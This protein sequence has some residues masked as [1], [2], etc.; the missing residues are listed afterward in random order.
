MHTSSKKHKTSYRLLFLLVCL[1]VITMIQPQIGYGQEPD[2]NQLYLP[3]ILSSGG[4]EA[5]PPV[6]SDDHDD[7]Y[8]AE[9]AQ[10]Y[11]PF[12]VSAVRRVVAPQDRDLYGEWGPLL[13]WP[14]IPVSAANLPDGRIITWAS[15]RVD[16]FPGGQPEFTYSSVWDPATGNF[17]T[18]NETGH[19][20]FCAHTVML[21]DGQVMAAGGRNTVVLTSLFNA[22]TNDW[23]RDD[24]MVDPRWYPT[25]VA[26]PDDEVFVVS[27][28]GGSNTAEVWDRNAGWRRLNNINWS[29]VANAAGFESHWW[30]YL[31]IAPD[32]RLAHTG[33]TDEMH[34]VT[35]SGNGS[36]TN[37]GSLV[38]N[39]WY[40]K[41]GAV[42]MYDVGKILIAGGAANTSGGS[43]DNVIT[44]D[45]NTNN[46]QVT[47]VADMTFAR[48]FPN[49][50]MLPNGKVL[51]LGGNTSGTKFSDN[52]TILAA[53]SWDPQT[54]QWTEL[55][56]AGAPR[57]YHSVGLLLPDGR[58]LSGGGGL[59]GGCS[60]NHQNS[61]IFSP[62]YLFQADGSLASRPSITNAPDTVGLGAT[63][64]V[65]ATP[66]MQQFSL[67]KMT[68]T[69]HGWSSDVRYLDVPFTETSSGTYQLTFNNNVNVLLAGYW[70][71]FALDN[72]GVPSEAKIVRITTDNTPWITPPGDQ[73]NFEED[74]VNLAITAGDPNGDTLTFSATGLPAG[75]SINSNTGIIAGTLPINS[76]TVN[77]V[78]VTVSDGTS[79]AS[80]SFTWSVF[81]SG[82]GNGQILREWWTGIGGNA[83]SSLT[84]NANYPDN[85]TGSETISI[86]ETPSNFA[87]SYG[88]RVRGYVHA[89]ITGQYRFWIAT[90][91]NGELWLSSDGNP[92]NVSLI[93]NVPGWTSPRQ[94]NKFTQQQS[95]LITLQAGQKYYIEALQKEGGGLDN[96]AVAWQIPG[97]S[98]EVIDGLYL[99]PPNTAPSV[100]NPGAQVSQINDIVSLTINAT[101]V[102]GDALTF[103]A[104]GLPSGLSI[105]ASTGEIA[106]TATTTGSFNATV[107]VND[108]TV[109]ND[110]SFVW[111]VNPEGTIISEFFESGAGDFTYQDDTFRGTNAASYASGAYLAT[112][113]DNGSGGLQVLLGGIDDNNILGMSGGWQTTFNL[114]QPATI[115]LSLRYILNLSSE[116]ESD[117]FGQT[118]FSLNGVLYGQGSNDYIAQINGNGGG[119][120]ID[121]TGWQTFSLNNVA[122]PAGTHTLVMGGYNNKKTFNNETTEVIIDDVLI[123][124]VTP[125][126]QTPVVTNP[127]NQTDIAGNTVS[128]NITASDGDND[129][130]TYSATGLP[131]GLAINNSTGEIAGTLT[132]GGVFNVTVTV[133]DGTDS[134]SA[135]F[136]WTVNISSINLAPMTS[137]PKEVGTS[138]NYTANASGGLNLQYKWDFGDGTGETSY[139]TSASINHTFNQP[140]RYLVTVYVKSDG[141]EEVFT[142]FWQAAYGTPTANRPA[143]SMSV[144][145]EMR[146]GADY[147][148]N[149]NPDNN[150]VSAFNTNNGN[151]VA[152]IPVQNAPRALAFAP[153]GRLWVTNKHSGSISIINTNTLAVVQTINLP[154]ASQPFGLAFDPA[155]SA[156]YVALEAAGQ[157]L[158]LNPNTGTQIDSVSLGLNIRHISVSA[159][160]SQ[161]LVSRFITPPM[162][163]EDT[164]NPQTEV[165]GNKL[166]GEVILVNASSMTIDNTVILQHSEEADSEASA[167][168]IPNYLGVAT[169]SPDGLSAWVPSKQDNIKRGLLR[170]GNDLDH[171]NTVRSISSRINLGSETEDYPARVDHDDGGIASTAIYG[172]YGSY[173]F[174]ALEGSREVAVLDPYGEAELFRFDVGFAPQGLA[175]SEDGLTLYVHNFLDRSVGVHDLTTLINA[176]E[177]TVSLIDTY[178]TVANE[179]LTA[180][181]LN[182]KKLF[183]DARDPR[184]GLQ[185]YISC[186][187]CHNDGGHDGRT[188]DLGNLGEGLRNTISLEGRAGTGHGPLHWSANFDEVHDFENQIRNLAFGL[189]LMTNADFIATEDPL[190]APK[191][192][193]SSDLDD[194]A[195]YVASLDSFADSPNRNSDGSLTSAAQAGETIFRT[196]DCA[197][198]HSGINFTDSAP[199][200]L[201]DIGTI[202]ASSGNRS[203]G[204]LPGL[205]T[206]TL[207]GVW[208][209]APYL[210][211]GSAA[212]IGDAIN[213]HNGVSFS[214]NDLDQLVAYLEQIDD[215]PATAPTNGAP[216]LTDP[217]NQTNTVGD[218]VNLGLVASDPNGDSLT[219]SASGLPAGLSLNTSSGV[220]SGNP[221]TAGVS[222]VSVSV[223][224]GLAS[225]N[226]S[227]VWTINDIPNNAPV[228]T[229]PGDQTNTIGDNVSLTLQAN[230]SDGDSL[231]FSASG[232][233]TGLNL[234]GNIISGNPTSAGV[235]NVSVSVS[236]GLASTSV[237]FTW[238]IEE[239]VVVGCGALIQEAEVASLSGNMVVG[240]DPNASGGQFI[241]APNGSGNKGF[242][243]PHNATFCFT[244]TEAG[245]YRIKGNVYAD[246]GH[247]DSFWVTVDG[248]PVGGNRW[249]VLRN[250]TYA[251]DYV[252]DFDTDQP[253]EFSLA[254][255]DHTLIVYVRDDGTR[256][257]KVS[258]ELVNPGSVNNPPSLINPG[259]QTNVAD[260]TVSLQINAS[261]PN[262]DSLTFT[263]SGLPDGLSLDANSGLIAG[264][265]TTPGTFNVSV[266][267]SDGDLSDTTS[268][269]WLVNDNVVGGCGPLTQ[270]AEL[271]TLSGNMVVG[272]DPNASGGQFIHAPNGSGN[273]G[274]GSPHNATFCMTVSQSGLYKI[275]GW[276][277][278]DAGN[279][280]SFWVTVD[281]QP[282]NGYRWDTLRNTLYAEDYVS[283]SSSGDD[284]S[285][286]LGVGDHTLSIYVRDDGTRLDRV[287]LEFAETASNQPPTIS[288]PGSQAHLIGDAVS[289]NIQALDPDNDPLT[290]SATGLPDGLSIDPNSG[291]IGGTPTV[292]GS[293]NTALT[294]SDGSETASI[295]FPWIISD[296]AVGCGSLLQEAENATLSGNMTIGS[297]PNASGGQYIHAPN[298]SGNKGFGTPHNATFCMT[299]TE[300]RTYKLKGWVYADAGN[301][302][303]FWVTINGEPVNGYRWD[304]LRNTLYAE[305]YVS[306]AATGNDIQLFLNPG[307]H[308]IIIYVRDD[309][310]RLDK[311]LLE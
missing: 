91:D 156:A 69:T 47:Q 33:P 194:L 299:V 161:V 127:G 305:D 198:C 12:D 196:A 57:N 121:S 99:S 50:I 246:A 81:P 284:V 114:A 102:D 147:V 150:T 13:S 205:D 78:T 100:T 92:A 243:S 264:T 213:A 220:I 56:D 34:W 7:A 80:T 132:A 248:L 84:G 290:F 11:P 181:V 154:Y 32:G 222:N 258:I 208:S 61:Q 6:E 303:S 277:Y 176:G 157:L 37:A 189:G 140:G 180:D 109:T 260:D 94:W 162:P 193:L 171:D 24:D 163:G 3:L 226:I 46:I 145:V 40:P 27:G 228:L 204:T 19:D 90:D 89:P 301:S 249:D 8:W 136:T 10:D 276:V 223:S 178:N 115:N 139:S 87:D 75:L 214:G 245:T 125:V 106:G 152:E 209:T 21:E 36:M 167:R 235:Y 149:V 128:L 17:Q 77:N 67:V 203:G 9:L 59:C 112:G 192:G 247:S 186:A 134:D 297:D 29:S 231:T 296:P 270:E 20:M 49:A 135:N 108:G 300:A 23:V 253:L 172:P 131:T 267:V 159:D 262:G 95:A 188:W 273:K 122:L 242:G 291:F 173:L 229:N 279:S 272:S 182:G 244:I 238:T 74:T 153:D 169:I 71:L 35:T 227:F 148:W 241:H 76:A 45:I 48:R 219:F 66:N 218:S 210:H 255:G 174:V 166:G 155:G 285:L 306:D 133:S 168:G 54:G 271:A 16:A 293:F 201:H 254:T 68:A 177:L 224:D 250:T 41:H 97:G 18:T 85:P 257:D 104:S 261:D 117:E 1:M 60:A 239:P 179:I 185:Q 288:N 199:N 225:A 212:T 269:S 265:L 211:D 298:G 137:S 274:F 88:T 44:V 151:K 280:D 160:G 202:K 73:T 25:A 126:N 308:T 116:Y 282:T 38:N 307:D 195:A 207:R 217:G 275:K 111:A 101:D 30:P 98:Q 215:Q 234:S 304:T 113:G 123:I 165:N 39:A 287:S 79:S 266:S 236:D 62:P 309:G 206:P 107:V 283:D 292:A 263:A 82:L 256:L 53:E 190:G 191:A 63:I 289:L 278:A 251:E 43:T 52:G 158:K 103:S 14:H 200:N 55:A 72:Q 252:T 83:I 70:M 295:S 64:S 5:S 31:H 58:V 216:S 42:A 22:N 237:S 93:A 183:Y 197:Q 311:L 164:V 4:E 119:G 138:V 65:Q 230:D 294:V 129:P 15:N 2:T 286:F 120:S 144:V 268:F 130:L 143:T 28:S 310:T 302:D 170:D 184:L 187:A 240:S 259:N 51:V 232:L 124:D 142:T 221:I 141:G 26:L 86:F 110:V 96:L 175:L 146:S 118:L 105:N 233:P 281:G